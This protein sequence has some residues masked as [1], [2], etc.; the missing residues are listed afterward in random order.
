MMKKIEIKN[1]R[2]STLVLALVLTMVLFIMGIAF[3]STTSIQRDMVENASDGQYVNDGVDVV[4]SKI[5]EVLK[6]DLFEDKAGYTG[7]LQGVA[8][9]DYPD[10]NNK[11]LASLTPEETSDDWDNNNSSDTFYCWPR[12]TDLWERF[13]WD[14]K[15]TLVGT[16]NYYWL[17]YHYDPDPFFRQDRNGDGAADY[18]QARYFLN[19]MSW[20]YMVEWDN[21]I[22]CR[23]VEDDE[24]ISDTLLAGGAEADQWL[25]DSNVTSDFNTF[26]NGLSSRNSYIADRLNLYQSG[27]NWYDKDNTNQAYA[28]GWSL[29]TTY[30]DN[31]ID[32]ADGMR[33]DADGDGVA[34]SRWVRLKQI[35]SEGDYLYAAV[36]IIDN[37]GMINLNTAFRKPGH[38]NFSGSGI[39]Q[40]YNPYD[41]SYVDNTGLLRAEDAELD[42]WD[43]S[44]VSHI[45]AWSLLRGTDIDNGYES[46]IF[47]DMLHYK[48]FP[49]VEYLKDY[50]FALNQAACPYIKYPREF[51][52]TTNNTFAFAALAPASGTPYTLTGFDLNDELELRN[53]FFLRTNVNTRVKND[54]Q[55]TYGNL[56]SGYTR[57]NKYDNSGGIFYYSTGWN[58]FEK[59][60]LLLTGDPPNDIRP[61]GNDQFSRRSITTTINKDRLVRPEFRYSSDISANDYKEDNIVANIRNSTRYDLDEFMNGLRRCNI[62]VNADSAGSVSEKDGDGIDDNII[63]WDHNS[64]TTADQVVYDIITLNNVTAAYYMAIKSIDSA[65][66]VNNLIRDHF[67]EHGVWS[68]GTPTVYSS[69][70][71]DYNT[72]MLA[73]QF[74]ANFEDYFDYNSSGEEETIIALDGTEYKDSGGTGRNHKER[75]FGFE[76]VARIEDDILCIS[77]IS[78]YKMTSNPVSEDSSSGE[79]K[80]SNDTLLPNGTY[81]AV[82]L[83]NPS[84]SSK[85]STADMKDYYLL[86]LDNNN[87]VKEM[88]DF[89]D[90]IDA[91]KTEYYGKDGTKVLPTV[92][93]AGG[94]DTVTILLYDLTTSHTYDSTVSNNG[95]KQYV[96]GSAAYGFLNTFPVSKLVYEAGENRVGTTFGSGSSDM[97]LYIDVRSSGLLDPVETSTQ[98]SIDDKIVLVRKGGTGSK[99][100]S[101]LTNTDD[102][103]PC[104]VVSLESIQHAF[105]VYKEFEVKEQS[106]TTNYDDAVDFLDE[107]YEDSSG[108]YQSR[109]ADNKLR[110]FIRKTNFGS[111]EILLPAYGKYNP[112]T[113]ESSVANPP[114]NTMLARIN[115]ETE[116]DNV[117]N[118]RWSSPGTYALSDPD[119]M[120]LYDDLSIGVHNMLGMKIED[121]DLRQLHDRFSIASNQC[122]FKSIGQL[123]DILVVGA[124][125]IE[126]DINND[127]NYPTDSTFATGSTDE[128]YFQPFIHSLA[129]ARQA[130]AVNGYCTYN[131]TELIGNPGRMNLGDELFARIPEFM[132]VIDYSRDG[133]DNDGNTDNFELAAICDDDIDQDTDGDDDNTANEIDAD[134]VLQYSYYNTDGIDQ[135][136][137]VDNVTGGLTNAE[138]LDAVDPASGFADEAEYMK[139]RVGE[140]EVDIYGRI[141]INTAPWYVIA[142]LPWVTEEMAQAIVAYRDKKRLDN[143][144]YYTI[145]SNLAAP[146]VNY[147]V[148]RA[149]GMWDAVL[150][151][152]K[153]ISINVQAIA[154]AENAPFQ[155]R[156]ERGFRSIGELMNVTHGL[157]G[158]YSSSFTTQLARIVN[159]LSDTGS[160]PSATFAGGWHEVFN[161]TNSKELGLVRGITYNNAFD[162]QRWG[163][164]RKRLDATNQTPEGDYMVQ[165]DSSNGVVKSI[166]DNRSTVASSLSGSWTLNDISTVTPFYDDEFT[167]ASNDNESKQAI[168]NK[169]SNL[170]TTRSD[171]FTAYI[172]VRVGRDGPQRR[173][174]GI[175][176][177]SNVYSGDD[178]VKLLALFQVPETQ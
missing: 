12:I 99:V 175:F 5:K 46:I 33:A 158:Q 121:F 10:E 41:G 126:A 63:D 49:S 150:N 157:R 111:S 132:T 160:N 85:D 13:D 35:N 147:S 113:F 102:V 52:D 31:P 141:N 159:S 146:A 54:W 153:L 151:Q 77:K 50:S 69:H 122:W 105:H 32:S 17:N 55:A 73:M 106:A 125:Y 89:N 61:N 78:F 66:N 176:D 26:L 93:A 131:N 178:E 90:F 76:D 16:S 62:N 149:N 60:G 165:T 59:G 97:F 8:S 145:D 118:I 129:K 140:Y 11:W 103:Y 154:E 119:V 152:A 128:I 44:S 57:T 9:Y 68:G 1:K 177:R 2:G 79:P 38:A 173:M 167:V 25:S 120:L 96:A 80:L 144:T 39:N 83:F 84:T 27:S 95:S 74:K 162:I 98:L 108:N 21:D 19:P 163:K 18:P 34:D 116:R 104:D 107:R 56:E 64:S 28:P 14:V 156:E 101:L 81:F 23:V 142:R 123:Q 24:S 65:E 134:E 115:I 168:F 172:L 47:N 53:R 130:S 170:I 42:N 29:K 72:E 91:A 51:G 155:V 20:R 58:W 75:Y 22:P 94:N 92:G 164:R 40:Y 117:E 110:N 133:I 87:Q 100:A 4:V 137:F 109:T 112:W 139:S 30:P 67:G 36:R 171:V 82:E 15:R 7:F 88:F 136:G 71:L 127:G 166:N 3:I 43:G 37:G 45:D 174:I 86:I 114:G 148:G 143:T 124:R 169:I 48:T 161:P 135:D 138:R 6:K 70:A